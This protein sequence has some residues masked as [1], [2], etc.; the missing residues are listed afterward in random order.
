MNEFIRY[1]VTDSLAV[2]TIDRPGKRNAMTFAMLEEWFEVEAC[3]SVHDLVDEPL[4][5]Y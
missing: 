1:E 2:I 4:E 5:D 3:E